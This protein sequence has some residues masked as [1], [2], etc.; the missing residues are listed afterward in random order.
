[1]R[2]MHRAIK[3]V[4]DDILGLRFNTAIAELIELKNEM[5]ALPA[6]PRALAENFTLMLAPLAPHIA[7]EL[8]Q[9]LGHKQSL[10]R[11]PWPAVDES[12]LA[13]SSIELPVQ[14]NGK[15]RGKVTVPATASESEVLAAAESAEAV[16]PWLAGKTVA[17]RIYVPGKLVSFVVR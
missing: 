1:D 16:K 6:V 17:K 13:E 14:V 9:K 7:E 2:R 4:A 10:A 12:K 11:H 5:T 8:W 15:L 3:K